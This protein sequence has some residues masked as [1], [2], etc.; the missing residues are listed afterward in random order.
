MSRSITAP[1][2]RKL[3]DAK[4]PLTLLDLRRRADFDA[5]T[6]MIPVARWLDHEKIEEWSKTLPR[7]R[8]IV[9]YCAHGKT[10]S[11]TAL[12]KL[13]ALGFKGRFIE[14]GMAGWKDAGG[15]LAAKS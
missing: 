15:A 6:G 9:L 7:D 14:G 11:N 10:I 2:L 12:D 8:E 5:D 3:L 13:Y 4:T 1:E